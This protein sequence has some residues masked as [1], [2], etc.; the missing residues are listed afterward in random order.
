[1]FVSGIVTAQ[2]EFI[3]KGGSGDGWSY[4]S[5]QQPRNDI[6]SGG[7][8]DGWASRATELTSLSVV[9]ND[10]GAEFIAWPNPTSGAV[11]VSLGE[12]YG[13]ISI[14]VKDALGKTLSSDV[15]HDKQ[16]VSLQL[17]GQN[18]FYFVEIVADGKAASIKVIRN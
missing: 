16:D 18:G 7:S 8:G 9:E 6:Y 17:A 12:R 3:F 13:N 15:Y 1:M 14:K 2:N 11:M 10:F 5:F 4:G